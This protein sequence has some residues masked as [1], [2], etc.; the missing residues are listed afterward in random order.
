VARERLTASE[1][2]NE[3]AAYSRRG[4][5]PGDFG[6][7]PGDE[8]PDAAEIVLR[9]GRLGFSRSRVATA[10][11]MSHDELERIEQRYE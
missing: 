9:A 7:S 1:V 8:L 5:P 6:I 4:A 3:L 11:G 10:L 2:D